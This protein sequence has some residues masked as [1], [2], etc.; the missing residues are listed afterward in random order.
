MPV[1]HLKQCTDWSIMWNR[2]GYRLDRFEPEVAGLV[3]FDDCPS[4]WTFSVSILGIIVSARVGLPDVNL[5]S[6]EGLAVGVFDCTDNE[7]FF[8]VRVGRQK[9]SVMDCP[10]VVRMKWTEETALGCMRRLGM[11]H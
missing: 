5:D 1:Q 10:S 11:I 3:A 2:I 9:F 7:T 6:L 8:A 4:I